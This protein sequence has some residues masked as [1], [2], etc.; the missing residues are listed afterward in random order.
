MASVVRYPIEALRRLAPPAHVRVA[1]RITAIERGRG[2]LADSTGTLEARFSA[3]P[4][5]LGAWV[6]AEGRWS[7]GSLE[8]TSFEV[9]NVPRSDFPDPRGEWVRL[10]ARSGRGLALVRTRGA[11]M[12]AI[13]RFFDERAFIEVETPLV[14]KSPGLDV[15]LSALEVD[16]L[17]E[18]RYL[19]TSP[20]YQMKRL[21]AGGLT[22]IYQIC[23]CFRRDEEG[24]QH[25]PEFTMLE[26]YRAFGGSEEIMR[27]TED[28][29]STVARSVMQDSTVIPARGRPLDVAPP[30]KRITVADAFRKLANVELQDVLDDEERFYRLLVEKIEPGL[31]YPKPVF[32]THWPASMASLARL[33]PDDPRYAD[34]VEAYIDGMEISNGFGELI[35]SVEQRDRFLCN[36]EERSERGLPVYPIDELF[37]AALDE[38][39]P[40]SGGNAL[41][42]DRL[43]MLLT[44]ATTID[45]VMAFP[46]SR[47]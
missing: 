14:V 32:L 6:V 1:G 36:Q 45:E 22:R 27:E 34:R 15:H 35:D 2:L 19:S 3:E 28:L 40:P 10:H 12:R 8:G 9:L 25:Q 18:R 24:A 41:G 4:P 31:G 21:L 29:V 37:L 5:P 30:W 7:G 26:W 43:L 33:H 46:Q 17:S 13:R 39:L 16:G 20:E 42:V 47:L 11:V 23:R 44:G 38:G